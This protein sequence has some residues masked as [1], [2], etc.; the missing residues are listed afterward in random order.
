MAALQPY[1][2]QVIEHARQ[3]ER[4]IA[5]NVGQ[6]INV[7]QYF[8]WFSFDVMGQFAFSR[9][10]NMLKDKKEH[11]AV[12][13]L[14]AGLGLVGPFTPVPW[15]VR[16][17]FDIPVLPIVRNFQKMEAWSAER[18]DERIK[19]TVDQPDVSQHL[20]SWS[21]KHDRLEKDRNTL[22]GDAIAMVIAGSDTASSTLIYLFYRLVQYP[23]HMERLQKELDSVG[24]IDNLKLLQS[25]PHL[26]G[27]INETLRLH[28]AVPTGGLRETPPQ[29][30]MISGRFVPGNTVICAP[31]YTLSRLESCFERASDFVPERWYSKPEMIKNKNAYA[32]FAL[33]RYN[34]IGKNVAYSEL[35]YMAALLAS[36]YDVAYAP[37]EDG[38]RVVEDMMDQ[39]TASPGQLRLVFKERNNISFI[40][41]H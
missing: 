7:N 24:S 37:G 31:R 6:P 39:F 38:R 17:A 18:I 3:L 29:G 22:Y 36:R 26:N 11:H 41:L 20:I 12:K 16:I 33:G 2:D 28:P 5:Q 21:A 34:C 9:S 32:P 13:M 4:A 15:L 1:E 40:E 10:F 25:L 30:I 19:N 8:Q 35:R 23:E 27:V 14:R